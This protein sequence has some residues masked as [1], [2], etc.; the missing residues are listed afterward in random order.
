MHSFSFNRRYGLAVVAEVPHSQSL[1]SKKCH[2]RM[3]AYGS[4]V[5]ALAACDQSAVAPDFASDAAFAKS[6]SSLTVTPSNASVSVGET[7]QLTASSSTVQWSSSAPGVATVSA[8]GL[9]LGVAAGEATITAKDRSKTAQAVITVTAAITAPSSTPDF[10]AVMRGVRPRGFAAVAYTLVQ[11]ATGSTAYYVATNGTDTGQGT[12]NQPFRTINKAAQIAVAGDV[13]II[14]SGT[15]QES[16]AVRN[17]GT[18]DKRIVFQAEERGKVVLTGG[19]YNFQP[20]GWT[21]GVMQDGPLYVTV[22]GLIFRDYAP[23]TSDT[24]S[25]VKAAVGAI[26]GW[27]I[28]DCLFDRAGYNGV[29]IRGND[30]EIVRSTFQ[31]HHTNAVTAWAPRGT[32][33]DNIKVIDTVLRGNHTRTDPLTGSAA[34]NVAK[35]LRTKETIIDNLESYENN[36][37]GFWFDTE[38]TGYTVRNSYFHDNGHRGLFLEINWASGLVENNV[39]AGNTSAGVTVANSRGVRITSNL[40]V[41][42]AQCIALINVDRGTDANGVSYLL[43]DVRMERNYCKSWSKYSG[44]HPMAGTF[45]T[46]A[47]MRLVADSNTYEPGSVSALSYWVNLGWQTT[48]SALQKNLG[49]ETNGQTGSIPW[50]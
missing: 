13:V 34:E 12:S 33:L 30:V 9:V 44:I 15:Y 40:F 6:G 31:Y 10:D 11:P 41:R 35:F 16:V 18:A 25:R 4:L 23:Q 32:S 39:F 21:S 37:S 26:R 38:N 1:R 20:Y 42:N 5:L 50:S 7:T 43:D 3:I 45:T 19:A 46:P 14:R 48:I 2:R 22:R 27:R 28:E 17:S 49:W 47:E 8:S 36:G 24:P 29:D